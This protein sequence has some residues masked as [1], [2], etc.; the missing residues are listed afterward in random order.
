MGPGQWWWTRVTGSSSYNWFKLRDWSLQTYVM[1][2]SVNY[3]YTRP[4]LLIRELLEPAHHH[5]SEYPHF[6]IGTHLHSPPKGHSPNGLLSYRPHGKLNGKN[7]GKWRVWDSLSIKAPKIWMQI[8]T[9]S[10]MVQLVCTFLCYKC[11]LHAVQWKLTPIIRRLMDLQLWLRGLCF[12]S[13]TFASELKLV[14]MR[15]SL[16]MISYICLIGFYI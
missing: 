2:Y 8:R 13:E 1:M 14:S 6:L 10:S 9:C 7:L 4:C 3:D 5:R 12:G 11:A 16:Q 15:T